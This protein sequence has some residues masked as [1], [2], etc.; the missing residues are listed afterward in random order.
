[1]MSSE[2][3]DRFNEFREGDM[4]YLSAIKNWEAIIVKPQAEQPALGPLAH[5]LR[6]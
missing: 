3:R 5:P 1:M 2:T 6:C 4:R